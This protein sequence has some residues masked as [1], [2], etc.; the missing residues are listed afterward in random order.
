MAATSSY[1]LSEFPEIRNN[2]ATM[3]TT[4]SETISKMTTHSSKVSSARAIRSSMIWSDQKKSTRRR[5]RVVDEVAA[6]GRARPP[7]LAGAAK[8]EGETTLALAD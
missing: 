2:T 7:V 1:Q 5:R 8:R 3:T 6:V 4:V